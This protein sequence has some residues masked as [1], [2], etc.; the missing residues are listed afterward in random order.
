MNQLL[1]RD[2]SSEV[3]L[4]M[5]EYKFLHAAVMICATYATHTDSFSPAILSAPPAE[6]INCKCYSKKA[7]YAT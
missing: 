2:Q 7:N 1:V 4:C 5:H 3:G 6:L